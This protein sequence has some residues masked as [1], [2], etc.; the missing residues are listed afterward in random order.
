MKEEDVQKNYFQ[1]HYGHFEFLV[2][3]RIYELMDELFVAK[4]FSKID[5][6][7]G[8]NQI[9]MKEEDVQKTAFRCHYGHFEFIVMRLD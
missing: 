2:I 9:Q 5:L 4:Y 3:P 8:Y 7:S 6:I 1:C